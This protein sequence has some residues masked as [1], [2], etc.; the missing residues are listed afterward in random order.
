MYHMKLGGK[1]VAIV[2]LAT[3]LNGCFV[4]SPYHGQVFSSRADSIPV[5]VWSNASTGSNMRIECHRAIEGALHE[6]MGEYTWQQI[7]SYHLWTSL[8]SLDSNGN[9]AHGFSG[10]VSLPSRCWHREYTSGV[11]R[12][13]TA[14]RFTERIGFDVRG[15]PK[16]RVAAVFDKLGLACAGQAIGT[17]GLWSGYLNE[18]CY[19]TFENSNQALP[20]LIIETPN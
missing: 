7:N 18:N 15:N 17:S 8:A 16:Y 2:L 10:N 12:S 3:V 14:L 19:P 1:G 13:R 20:F 9:L 5:Q 11:P 4:S 6:P